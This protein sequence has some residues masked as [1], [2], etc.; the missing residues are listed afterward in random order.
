MKVRLTLQECAP[1]RPDKYLL[2]EEQRERLH[3]VMREWFDGEYMAVEVDLE[4]G[5]ARIVCDGDEEA[6]KSLEPDPSLI[7]AIA[8]YDLPSSVFVCARCGACKDEREHYEDSVCDDC[9]RKEGK[10]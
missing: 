8:V 9:A 2:T 3:E 1:T 5:D 7:A 4:T 6:P 10:P